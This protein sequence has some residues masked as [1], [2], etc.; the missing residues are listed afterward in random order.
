MAVV[1]VYDDP[2][3]IRRG[4]VGRGLDA[5]RTS[6]LPEGARAQLEE[7]LRTVTASVFG[8]EA[9]SVTT[10]LAVGRPVEQIIAHARAFRADLVVVGTTG[11]TGALRLLLGSVA[12]KV[13]RRA[14]LPVLTVP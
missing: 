1:H 8:A 14:T 10:E 3:D 13:V 5:P 9:E 12:E 7:A 11:R 2:G 6:A 4:I